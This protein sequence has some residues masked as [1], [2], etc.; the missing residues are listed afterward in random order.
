MA[1]S[2]EPSPV[3][4]TGRRPAEPAGLLLKTTFAPTRSTRCPGASKP[5]A[6]SAATAQARSTCVEADQSAPGGPL[7]RV[8]EHPP[9]DCPR[10]MRQCRGVASSRLP[11]A[12]SRHMARASSRRESLQELLV[13]PG[14]IGLGREHVDNSRIEPFRDERQQ[15]R[16]DPVSR[17]PHIVVRGIV[18]ERDVGPLRETPEPPSRE[19]SSSGLMTMPL[20][21]CIAARPRVPAPRIRR[22]RKVSA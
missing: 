12:T 3:E 10:K 5:P 6:P 13:C 14:E 7:M 20:R 1:E 22:S 21:G 11:A 18:H 2:R 16:P 8:V 19:Q 17:N 15:F 4:T 9:R